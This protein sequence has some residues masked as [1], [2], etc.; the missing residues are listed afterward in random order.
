MW[1]NVYDYDYGLKVTCLCMWYDVYDYG[2]GP[3]VTCFYFKGI[4]SELTDDSAVQ[5]CKSYEEKVSTQQ[6]ESKSLFSPEDLRF[7]QVYR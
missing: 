1:Y 7:Y 3:K 6:K 2:Y 4:C 5:I